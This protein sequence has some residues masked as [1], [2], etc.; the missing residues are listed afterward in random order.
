MSMQVTGVVGPASL[1]NTTGTAPLRQS[2]FGSL[3]TAET[4]G[5]HFE[6]TLNGN[7]FVYTIASQ[8]LLL[9]ATTGG[10]P[11][12]INPVGSGVIFV[13]TALRISFISGTTVIGGVVLATT[14]SVGGGAATAAPIATATLVA[15]K[16]AMRGG[17]AASRCLWSP[18]TNTFT[19]APTVDFATGINLGAAAPTGSGSYEAKFDGS[20]AYYPGTAMS[21][22][23]T[24][25]TSTALFACTI[26]GIEVPLPPG[27]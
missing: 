21:V 23:Y 5:K 25:T 12:V 8:A 1:A 17:S 22:C 13:P 20:I 7:A 11:T 2:K 18:T 16:P 3:V 9:S 4:N 26:L 27:S 24:V 6:E 10:H 14:L 19:A 15:A